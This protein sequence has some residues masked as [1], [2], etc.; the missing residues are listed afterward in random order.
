MT[1]KVAQVACAA[2]LMIV[3]SAVLADVSDV[4]LTIHALSGRAEGSL[5]ITADQGTWEGE[6]FFWSTDVAIPIM[7]GSEVLGTVGPGRLELYADPSVGIG[8]SLQAG[9]AETQFTISSAMLTFPPIQP[10]A[11]ART[12]GAFTVMDFMG[13]GAA[14]TG[15]LPGGFAYRAYL[16]D[17]TIFYQAIQS[18][19]VLP[20]ETP[21]AGSFEYPPGGGYAI[22]PGTGGMRAEI[23]CALTPHAFASGSA[24][25]EI[26]PEPAGL[27]LLAVGIGLV[28]RR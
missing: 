15:T 18:I 8:F 27:L 5:E 20:T 16:G 2:A 23:G 21:V 19:V 3:S 14:L 11:L 4:V 10:L 12:S 22:I 25:F 13:E 24:V 7:S 6:N 1:S 26:I 9:D 28:R 17:G